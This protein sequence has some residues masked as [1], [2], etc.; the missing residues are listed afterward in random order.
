MMQF[1]T[2][3]AI[4]CPH[5]SK[6]SW[7]F[8]VA[9]HAANRKNI[10]SSCWLNPHA[11]EAS[12]SWCTSEPSL[13]LLTSMARGKWWSTRGVY[14]PLIFADTGHKMDCSLEGTRSITTYLAWR[15]QSSVT[16][17]VPP[18]CWQI[19]NTAFYLA[20]EIEDRVSC[21][22]K[23]VLVACYD[24]GY[25]CGPDWWMRLDKKKHVRAV[26]ANEDEQ[27]ECRV[28]CS[29]QMPQADNVGCNRC[30]IR[31]P[32]HA[33]LGCDAWTMAHCWRLKEDAI[34]WL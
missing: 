5:A 1:E 9:H 8:A 10:A 19:G 33:E 29:F 32:W 28:H 12:L 4:F 27:V 31:D 6:V 20:C 15:W 26:G 13:Q 22:L 23:L 17:R 30:G 16:W 3:H 11:I 7:V 21:F 34:C 25:T 18:H 2:L 14:T 24:R